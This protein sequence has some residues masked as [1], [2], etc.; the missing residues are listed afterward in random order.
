MTLNS[1]S[2]VFTL[3]KVFPIYQQITV[4]SKLI[5]VALS[6]FGDLF[7]PPQFAYNLT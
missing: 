5:F 3:R 4:S 2:G 6:L 1:P 7:M